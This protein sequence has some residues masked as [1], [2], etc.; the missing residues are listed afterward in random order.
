MSQG[1]NCTIAFQ[2]YPGTKSSHKSSQSLHGCQK[3]DE[4]VALFSKNLVLHAKRSGGW[5]VQRWNTMKKH[6]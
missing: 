4:I 1:K 3:S 2:D 5:H 6:W